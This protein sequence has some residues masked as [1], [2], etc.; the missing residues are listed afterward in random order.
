MR[1]SDLALQE[2]SS[3]VHSLDPCVVPPPV[4]SKSSSTDILQSTPDLASGTELPTP[5]LTSPSS[6]S[7]NTTSDSISNLL[8]GQ[9]G[10]HQLFLD[11][12]T[13]LTA[14]E[15]AVHQLHVRVEGM[16]HSLSVLRDQ[17]TA[18]TALRVQAQNERD[19]A[20]KDDASAA[21]VVERYMT[22]TQ[23][24]HNTVHRHLDNL[25]TRSASTQTTL[26]KEV[27]GLRNRLRAE[28]ERSQRLRGASDEMG[29]NMSRE[30]AGRRREVAMRLKMLA[31]EEKRE[32]KVEIWLDRVRR[33]RDGAEGAVLEPDILE[34]LVDEG[35]EAVTP[36]VAGNEVGKGKQPGWRG[37]LGKTK[38]SVETGAIGDESSEAR[39][40]LAEE[41]V[42]T[43]VLDLQV[44]MGRRMELEKQRVDWLAREAVDGV[45]P[46]DGEADGHLMFDAGD[47]DEDE[48]VI[49]L[50]AAHGKPGGEEDG[51]TVNDGAAMLDVETPPLPSAVSKKSPLIGH[52]RDLFAPLTSRHIPLQKTLHDLSLSLTSLRSS[53]PLPPAQPE[54][55][56]PTRS[57]K[58]AFPR[59]SLKTVAPT[60]D[61]ILANLLDS[62]HEVIEDARVDHEIAVADGERVYRGFE[63]LLGVGVGSGALQG[64]GVMRDAREYVTD[65]RQEEGFAKLA[66]RVEN[67]E[68]DL[69]LLKRTVH[70]VEGMEVD[71]G[72]EDV[73]KGKRSIW[74]NLELR[75]VTPTTT[76]IAASPIVIP[77]P[78]SEFGDPS[79]KPSLLSSVGSVGRSFSAS[80][81][82]APRRVSGLAGGLYRGPKGSLGGPAARSKDRDTDG[83]L[84][85]EDDVE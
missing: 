75:T 21:K 37:L 4:P 53:L 82:G 67:V 31:V 48:M 24:T 15:R 51:S 47:Q 79:R 34:I 9:R 65:K 13:T 78:D 69:A 8:I 43:L 49:G 70:E 26:R 81:I 68:H 46:T 39:V 35:V 54:A 76:R 18:E 12:T 41:L 22:F 62:I 28:T 30:A 77:S 40:M 38:P 25:R 50:D 3:L 63:A 73:G 42:N 55:P 57:K 64:K 74:Q 29:E 20:L 58:S 44:E 7:I 17:L 61:P 27:L 52:L 5:P 19:K 84:M 33:A 11:F 36:E 71:K 14:K 23:K 85:E 59:L 16:E 60:S 83:L 56:T 10:V 80:V 66:K 6:T 45:D 32:R 2:Y 72:E 1:G